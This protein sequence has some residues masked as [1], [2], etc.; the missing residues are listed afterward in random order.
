MS[1]VKRSRLINA[2]VLILLAIALV[3]VLV[4]PSGPLASVLYPLDYGN[5]TVTVH[6]VTNT[7]LASVDIRIANSEHERWV[8]LSETT[9]LKDGHGMLFVH[10][11]TGTYTYVMRNMSFPID[12]VFIDADGQITEI[13]HAPVADDPENPDRRYRGEGRYVLEVPY[14]WTNQTGISV[15]DRVS[16]PERVHD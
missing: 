12:I 3:L 7:T 15:G 1:P 11:Q 6:D 8:G 9:D 10:E 13:H 16:I 4:S 2:I 14:G 5:A